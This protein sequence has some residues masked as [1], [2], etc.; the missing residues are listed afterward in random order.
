M[1]IRRTRQHECHGAAARLRRAQPAAGPAA[2]AAIAAALILSACSSPP[3]RRAE[4]PATRPPVGSEA[5]G[6]SVP[7]RG[8]GG[9]YLDDGPGDNPPAPEMLAAI[10]DALPKAEVLHRFANRPYTVM[11]QDFVPRTQVGEFRQSG[12]ASWY[13]RRFHG[14]KTASGEIYDMYGMTAAHPTL[15]IPSYVRVTHRGNGRS[16]IVR[17]N[18]R[19]PFLNGR[20]C[21]LS[22]T[23]AW[24]LGLLGQGSGEVELEAVMPGSTQLAAAAPPPA[25]RLASI[26]AAPRDAAPALDAPDEIE[27]LARADMASAAAQGA[28]TPAVPESESAAGTYL[29]LGAFAARANAESFRDHLAREMD[30]LNERILL[31]A[32]DGKFRVQLGPYRT[33]AAAD[34]VARRIRASL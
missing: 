23:A 25:L 6:A 10:P 17:V 1:Q 8:A 29:Q 7:R 27:L 9:Y 20:I 31:S 24:K 32:S 28:A 15:P 4:S 12:R 33:R 14:L 22:Y 26:E 19:G 16:V 21:D 2:L 5:P 30:W 3:P 11:G 34:D 13:G 18:D